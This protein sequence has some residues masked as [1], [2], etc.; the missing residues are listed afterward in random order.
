MLLNS[1][2]SLN[3][4]EVL[5]L[6]TLE[7]QAVIG[8]GQRNPFSSPRFVR[9]KPQTYPLDVSTKKHYGCTLKSIPVN[10]VRLS[11]EQ[12]RKNLSVLEMDYSFSYMKTTDMMLRIT[13]ELS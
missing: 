11:S 9:Y 10:P 7:S 1:S 4:R 12:Q 3:L 13:K 8:W 6:T 2:A 5:G